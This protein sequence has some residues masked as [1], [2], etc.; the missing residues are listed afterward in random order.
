MFTHHVRKQI[1]AC[2]KRA[3]QG[4]NDTITQVIA[5]YTEKKTAHMALAYLLHDTKE[6]LNT[7][8]KDI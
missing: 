1:F 8:Q 2:V 4:E 5:K 6:S 7:F 3:D